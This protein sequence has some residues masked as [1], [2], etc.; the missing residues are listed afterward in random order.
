M[1]LHR[2][3]GQAVGYG[4]ALRDALGHVVDGEWQVREP[5]NTILDQ[6]EGPHARGANLVAAVFR[7]FLS[8]YKNRVADLFRIASS[9]SGILRDGEID[10][11]LVKRLAGEAAKSARHILRMC[12]RAMD[13]IPPVNVGFGDYFRAIITADH[14]LYPDDDFGYRTAIIEAFTAWGLYPNGLPVITEKALLCPE[15]REAA[16]DMGIS[17]V[18]DTLEATF[19]A[20]VSRPQAIFDKVK[21]ELDT[22][23]GGGSEF[24]NNLERKRCHINEILDKT[25]E[26]STLSNRSTNILVTNL[27]KSNIIGKQPS[28]I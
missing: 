24:I 12:I 8:I 5:D 22:D 20:L 11:D 23:N 13:Y 16:A 7:A 28:R 2:N 14:D 10:P 21:N 17:K 27:T 15:L 3:F 6:L 18:S 9:G 4:A 25:Y 19:G 26:E 1:P